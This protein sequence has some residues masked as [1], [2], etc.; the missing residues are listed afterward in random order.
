[1]ESKLQSKARAQ[2]SRMVD[3]ILFHYGTTTV[4]HLRLAP[5]EANAVA[6][7][8]VPSSRGGAERRCSVNRIP[9]RR[10]EP[11]HPDHGGSGRVG[12]AERPCS[13]SGECREAS[14]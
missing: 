1:M 11:A 9:R 4:R 10:R 8:S 12:G 2:Q 6:S 3:E 7:R 5:G 14:L 13:S